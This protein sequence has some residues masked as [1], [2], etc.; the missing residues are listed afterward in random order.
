M[1][2]YVNFAMEVVASEDK[3]TAVWPSCPAPGWKSGVNRLTGYPS[4]QPLVI[5]GH[6]LDLHGPYIK[7]CTT[8]FQPVDGCFGAEAQDPFKVS[9]QMLVNQSIWPPWGHSGPIGVGLSGTAFSEYGF[10]VMSSFESMSATLSPENWGINQEVWAQRNYPCDNFIHAF[11]GK[12][13][14]NVSAVGAVALQRQTWQCMIAQA[15]A[16][17]QYTEALRSM[18]TVLVQFWQYNE[19]W[20]TGGWGSIEYGTPVEGQVIGGRWKPLQHFLRRSIFATVGAACLDDGRCYVRNDGKTAFTGSLRLSLIALSTGRTAWTSTQPLSIAR[21]A[22]T[23]QWVCVRGTYA[24][25]ANCTAWDQILTDAQCTKA[26]C[27]FNADVLNGSDSSLASSASATLLSSNQQL[28]LPPGQLEVA[29]N[30]IVTAVVGTPNADGL[31]PVT[32]T[33]TATALLV[34]LTTLAPG[35]F[36]DN[37]FL[38]TQHAPVVLL[39]TPYGP[40]DAAALRASLRVVHLAEYL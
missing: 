23:V 28:L 34:T 11:F 7:G 17:K 13:H 24:P 14:S 40:A 38:L 29:P 1:T 39:F 36:S 37:A 20:P 21:G 22:H 30:A 25:G 32:V 12:D 3:T 4:G 10:T 5:G 9:T 31:I 16:Q 35:V 18:N 27:V 19:I 26:T 6:T 33:A 8:A 2:L 15:L